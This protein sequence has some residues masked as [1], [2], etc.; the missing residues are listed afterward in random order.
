M[1]YP[2]HLAQH[3]RYVDNRVDQSVNPVFRI[4]VDPAQPDEDYSV[5]GFRTYTQVGE[6]AVRATGQMVRPRP[7]RAPERPPPTEPA[8][9]G[10]S[11]PGDPLIHLAHENVRAWPLPAALCGHYVS[12]TRAL[13]RGLVDGVDV[14]SICAGLRDQLVETARVRQGMLEIPAALIA[15]LIDASSQPCACVNCNRAG[16]ARDARTAETCRNKAIHAH[17]RALK[18][19]WGNLDTEQRVE[20]L[21]GNTFT[22][23]APRSKT[24]Y[25]VAWEYSGNVYAPEKGQRFCIVPAEYSLPLPDLLLAQKLLIEADEQRF[26]RTANKL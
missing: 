2:W 26:L 21:N 1:D 10:V 23:V 17:L 4:A 15:R 6:R 3:F 11:A 12:R 16:R 7:H 5:V 13:R 8:F 24:R 18:L 22:V 9:S 14:C 19:L 25:V 20:F